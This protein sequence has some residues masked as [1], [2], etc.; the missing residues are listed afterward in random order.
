MPE[1]V[2]TTRPRT[3]PPKTLAGWKTLARSCFG[4]LAADLGI[5]RAGDDGEVVDADRGVDAGFDDD[6]LVATR[7]DGAG[8]G[9]E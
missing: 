4:D 9:E 5:V 2:R 7:D 8:I 6:G 1:K 3:G